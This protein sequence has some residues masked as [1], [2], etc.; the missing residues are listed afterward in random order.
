MSGTEGVA[1][2]YF[3]HESSY[4]DEDVIIGE[5]TKIW[6][7]CHVQAGA[8]IGEN[9]VLGQNVNISNRVKIGNGVKIQNNVSVYEGVGK[10]QGTV[11][12]NGNMAS[13][14]GECQVKVPIRQLF[15]MHGKEGWRIRTRAKAQIVNPTKMIRRCRWVGNMFSD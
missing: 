12:K 11:D 3:V 9:C 2:N 14:T 8:V 13:V 4:I 1:Q 7:F 5:G 15:T 10:V 6:H